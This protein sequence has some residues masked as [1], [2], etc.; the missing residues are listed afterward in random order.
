MLDKYNF[1]DV[2]AAMPYVGDDEEIFEVIV[3]TYLEEEK[4]AALQQ[5]FDAQ[6]W[7]NYRITVHGIKST[8]YTIGATALGDK[9]KESEF[10]IK[11][12]NIDGAISRHEDLMNDYKAMLDNIRAVVEG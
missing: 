5:Y 2:E 10:C 7:P 6:D 3:A 1:L 8:S 11:D 9:A 12:G 4:T